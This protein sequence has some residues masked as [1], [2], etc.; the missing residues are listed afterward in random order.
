MTVKELKQKLHEYPDNM[1]VFICGGKTEFEFGL[2]NS[3]R[4]KNIRFYDSDDSEVE[5]FDDC[6]VL[7]EE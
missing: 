2:L 3:V 6:V 1:E 5:A 4:K 7:D